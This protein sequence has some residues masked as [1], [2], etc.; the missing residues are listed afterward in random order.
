MKAVGIIAE[1]NPFHNG[2]AY[3]INKIRQETGADVVVVAMSGH[4]TQ[5]GE[6][7]SFTKW[8]RA[9]LALLGGADLIVELPFVFASRSGE[10]FAAGG[11]RLLDALGICALSFGTESTSLTPLLTSAR[12]QLLPTL[13]ETLAPYLAQG[14]P[15]AAALSSLLEAKYHISSEITSAPNNILTIEYLKAILR[16]APHIIPHPI[17]RHG[18]AHHSTDFT[19]ESYASS[20]AIRQRLKSSTPALSS[21]TDY[22]PPA[23]L[24]YLLQYYEAN[25]G[26]PDSERLA[27]FVFGL[28]ATTD[29][30]R[31][32]HTAGISEGLENKFL[33]ASLRVSTLEELLDHVKTRRYPRTRLSRIIL[34]YLLGSTASSIAQFDLSGPQY[35]RV[36][37]MNERGQAYLR[38]RKKKTPL[39]II[40]KLTSHFN[41]YDLADPQGDPLKNMLA[42]DVRTANLYARLF[43]APL[44]INQDFTTSPVRISID[45]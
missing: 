9:H 34:H 38:T 28:L 27:P 10:Y 7:A 8:Q 43:G 2:H 25:G 33:S 41:Q 15:Y 18:S 19:A 40:T 23:S 42:F 20:S 37:G 11:V 32:T 45:K 3:Q 17:V 26:L 4:F 29:K 6:A 31:L 21:L 16:Y 44:A 24:P 12:I 1:Y 30:S 39:P 22:I 36:L 13:G 14:L 5:R 35:I